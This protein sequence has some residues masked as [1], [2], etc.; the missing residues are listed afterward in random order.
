MTVELGLEENGYVGEN[1]YSYVRPLR[2]QE[3]WVG[4]YLLA[5]MTYPPY[6]LKTTTIQRARVHG[7]P[8]GHR[9]SLLAP[10]GPKSG[11]YLLM[12]A[13]LNGRT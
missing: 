2:E 9:P 13:S 3:M 10:S 1:G 12:V 4:A 8:R 11:A 6:S 5:A 7:A